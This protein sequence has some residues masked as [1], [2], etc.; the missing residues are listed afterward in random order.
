MR[1]QILSLSREME[2]IIRDTEIT[3]SRD[4]ALLEIMPSAIQAWKSD[5]PTTATF[6]HQNRKQKNDDKIPT[7]TPGSTV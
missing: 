7:P 5:C 1:F 6:L 2:L 3:P 4:Q